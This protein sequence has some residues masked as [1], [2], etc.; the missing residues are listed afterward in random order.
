MLTVEDK[1]RIETYAKV[2][3][4]TSEIVAFHITFVDPCQ[5]AVIT[6]NTDIFKDYDY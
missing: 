1:Y 3:E 4:I 2:G 5:D 6:L